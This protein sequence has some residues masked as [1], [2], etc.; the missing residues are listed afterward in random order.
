MRHSRIKRSLCIGVFLVCFC[1]C[2]KIVLEQTDEAI[3]V[4]EDAM[5]TENRLEEDLPSAQ[6]S[7]MMVRSVEPTIGIKRNAATVE[8][9]GSF[10]IRVFFDPEDAPEDAVLIPELTEG[11]MRAAGAVYELSLCCGDQA[12]GVTVEIVDTTPPVILGAEDLTI[13][14][15]DSVSY[16]K[17]ITLS[18]NADGEISLEI[19]NDSVDLEKEG[20]YPVRYVATDVSGN[21]SEEEIILY[22][23]ERSDL[24]KEVDEL[25]DALIGELV[26]DDMTKWDICYALWNWCRTKIRYSYSAGERT[27]YAGAF[28]GLH[29]KCGD[30]Y[31]Y[32]ATFTILLEKCGIETMEIRRVGGTSDHWWNLVNLGD[33]WYHCD[34]SPRR[35]GDHYRCFMQTDAQVQAYTESYPEHP[36]YYVFDDTL[37]PE[38]G[39]EILYGE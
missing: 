22:V 4:V 9:G 39:T 5:E 35:N 10:D 8:A 18:D 26:T 12:V 6:E 11:Q 36:N 27:I 15:G 33:G 34:S 30:C 17:G 1:I 20:E 16:R 24:E 2:V 29:D 19:K 32:Y 23:L 28:E 31:V 25:A 3:P 7:V 37:Y 21:V 13:Y 38:R 14:V